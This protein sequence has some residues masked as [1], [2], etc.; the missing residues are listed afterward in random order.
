MPIFADTWHLYR[1]KGFLTLPTKGK[2][3]F[4]KNFSDYVKSGITEDEY[5][6]WARNYPDNNIALLCGSVIPSINKIIIAV[7]VD[8]PEML[9][10]VKSALM[11]D[12]AVYCAKRGAKGETIFV[13]GSPDIKNRKMSKKGD[14]R[15]AVEILANGNI[16]ILPPSIHP[17]TK[18][19]YQW[20][21]KSLCDIDAA[22]L[23]MF[24]NETRDEIY[25]RLNDD[26]DAFLQLDAMQASEGDNPGNVHDIALKVT[27]ALV[28]R[29][30]S[31]D[32]TI[33]RV[34]YA[35]KR[36]YNK[37]GKKYDENTVFSEIRQMF[38]T[39]KD[40]GF[41]KGN[42][43]IPP[44]RKVANWLMS[45]LSPSVYSNGVLR[46]YEDGHWKGVD[47][48]QVEKDA[49]I[50]FSGVS[51][52][53]TIEGIKIA[54]AT[55]YDSA[56]SRTE[57]VKPQDDLHHPSR[58]K[59]C[60]L[61]GTLNMR[62]MKLEEHNMENHLTH[63]LDLNWVDD[64]QC[65]V[66]EKFVL[67]TFQGDEKSVGVWD[68]FCGWTLVNDMRFHKMLFLLGP[69]G[70]G[71]GTLS[72]VLMSLHPMSA[73]GSVGITD[74]NDERKRTS[75]VGKLVN[76]SGEQNRMNLVSDAYLK[77]ITGGDPVDVRRLYGETQ[78]NVYLTVRFL[79]LVN[80]MP[81]ISTAGEAMR[82]RLMILNCNNIVKEPDIHLTEKLL[83][84]RSGILRRWAIALGRLYER[85]GFDEPL[86]S[87]EEVENYLEES[88]S[89]A[90]W[91]KERCETERGVYTSSQLLYSDYNAFCKASGIR[92]VMNQ[93][94]WGRRLTQMGFSAVTQ[95][96]GAGGKNCKARAVQ[97]GQDNTN[98]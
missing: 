5:R 67:D 72:R 71:K 82:R 2:V 77:K 57:G 56:F 59:V 54:T 12:G 10:H 84:E 42:D 89:V 48:R 69:G 33:K 8:D 19:P 66:Y 16:T 24:E 31:Q 40:K 85:E 28:R 91:L 55:V 92:W 34:S 65:P 29:S 94:E 17:E 50:E 23:P 11:V 52:K 20:T 90:Y 38:Q 18:K 21:T 22:D 53:S 6:E 62:E 25:C 49:F 13:V 36:A 39:A 58:Y 3:P 86:S 74:L 80:E 45:T 27:A 78:N 32:Y 43:K 15:P 79:E 64:A 68:E 97:I 87:K 88:D 75:L 14:S 76:V 61:N 30:W 41:D 70:N 96:V 7:D 4:F 60:L 83:R 93:V 46:R 9:N 73:I 37:I 1:S 98:I 51:R 26:A 44:E 95:R 81:A 63:Q 47:T 35:Y